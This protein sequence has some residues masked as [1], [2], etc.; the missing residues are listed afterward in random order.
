MDRKAVQSLFRQIQ[1]GEEIQKP[2]SLLSRIKP[3]DAA[4]KLSGLPYSLLSNLE[5]ARFWQEIWLN[6]LRGRKRESFLKD[7]RIPKANEFPRIRDA[8]LA[9]FQE[10]IRIANSE[11][12]EHHMES[13]D[14]AVNYL[15]AIAIHDSYHLGQINLLK[16]AL[17]L[18]SGSK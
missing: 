16:R 2:D 11:P 8:F 15:L 3:E 4:R 10:A 18:K 1:T 12:F 14:R 7:W 5:H 13:D 17:R 6:R 9:D